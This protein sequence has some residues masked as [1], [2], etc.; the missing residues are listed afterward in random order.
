MIVFCSGSHNEF[1]SLDSFVSEFILGKHSSEY[2]SEQS[3][4]ILFHYE[5]SSYPL[6]ISFISAIGIHKVFLK[7]FTGNFDLIDIFYKN[8][9]SCIP[10]IG[11]ICF[12]FSQE[13]FCDIYCQSS[14]YFSISIDSPSFSIFFQVSWFHSECLI[15]IFFC[16]FHY[17]NISKY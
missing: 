6:K 1:Y 8:E 5:L 3:L 12:V 10:M 17:K 7:L 11:I 14:E 16:E 9:I 13:Q 4:R 2:C 15:E